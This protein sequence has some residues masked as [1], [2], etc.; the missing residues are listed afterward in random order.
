MIIKKKKN[1]SKRLDSFT[2]YFHFFFFY[3]N[4]F[5]DNMNSDRRLRLTIAKVRRIF[6][7][8]DLGYSKNL[9]LPTWTP[10]S[11][12]SIFQ[13]V[14]S[15]SKSHNSAKWSTD[16]NNVIYWVQWDPFRGQTNAI[17][18]IFGSSRHYNESRNLSISCPSLHLTKTTI[19]YITFLT[20]DMF[21][22]NITN[23]ALL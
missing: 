8:V 5:C 14:W 2:I 15:D 6:L 17:Y 13:E 22:R 21:I 11:S 3:L 18:F 16:S 1:N 19:D 10:Q 20:N 7:T 12:L 4:S 23:S 9:I